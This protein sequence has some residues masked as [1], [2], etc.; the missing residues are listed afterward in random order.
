MYVHHM[1]IG[2]S[3]LGA[4]EL[5]RET[6]A[7]GHDVLVLAPPGGALW[8]VADRFGLDTE[9][10]PTHLTWPSPRNMARVVSAVRRTRADVVHAHE[11]G[12]A[13]DV[14]LGT[15][16]L[17]GTP[18]VVTTMSMYVS[19]Y[20]PR[21]LPL[22]VGT[23]DLAEDAEGR[24]YRQVELLEPPV[25]TVANAPGVA[26]GPVA[27]ARWGF[28]PDDV[29][30][31]VV[32]RLTDDLD[33]TAGVLEAM[34]V[35][36]QAGPASPV[37]LLVV[38]DGPR[39]DAVVARAEKVNAELG[40]PAVVVAGALDDPRPAYDAADVVI[41]MGSSVLK[42]MAFGKP[43]VV[44]G[45]R[46]Y[47]RAL[48]EQSL[49]VFLG[50]GWFGAGGAGAAALAAALSPL[51]RDAGLRAERGAFGHRVVT[52]RYSLVASA[53]RMEQVYRAAA[54]TGRRSPRDLARLG[55]RVAWDVVRGRL[56]ERPARD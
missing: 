49:A 23:R 14:A 54:A 43:V 26:G 34:D 31:S 40:R 37:R 18:A 1:E 38:G 25:D 3:Q 16:L 4:L 53:E 13:I 8:E 9:T 20:I 56:R 48:D 33:K 47:W 41:G 30:V 51:V 11:W 15:H 19:G 36:E 6:M 27:R 42:G 45:E 24:G 35:V 12:P 46:G 50:Q 28:G 39:S 55:A 21:H 5:A 2:G 32:C 7:R 52:E 22:V 44:Q 29:V 10:L 17:L